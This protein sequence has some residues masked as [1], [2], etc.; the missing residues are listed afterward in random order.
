[1]SK[2]ER[3]LV[4]C[5]DR[6]DDIGEKT[7]F[8]GPIIGRDNVVKAAIELGIADPEDSDVNALFESIRLF[9]EM[10]KEH[11]TQIA[12]IT[13]N[14]N[15]GIV[16]DKEV[17]SQ[18]KEVLKNFKADSAVLVSDGSEDEY[19]IPIIQSNVP[20]FS[21]RRVVVKQSEKLESTYYKIKDFLEETMENPK[22]ARLFF[23]LPAITLLVYAAFGMEGWRLIFGAIGGYLFLKGFKLDKYVVSAIEE[24]KTSLTRRRFA[25]FTYIVGIVLAVLASVKGYDA[26]I[27]WI[28]IG[29]FETASAFIADSIYIFYLACI[30][31][32][33]GKTLSRG[34][35]SGKTVLSISIFGF[36]V[37]FVIHNAANLILDPSIS[38]FNFIFS[39]IIGFALIFVA[40]GIELKR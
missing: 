13:G 2:K 12:V 16:S 19:V 8:T 26:A 20:V 7:S 9:D 36:A 37:S 10:K 15:V 40:V 1:M 32:W 38:M 35:R 30:I 31:A 11:E 17:S 27:S 5:V 24:L 14:K 18:L 28:N 33:I 6:D 21:V 25:F 3:I 29:L 4:L 23:G 34:K 39:I 22:Y